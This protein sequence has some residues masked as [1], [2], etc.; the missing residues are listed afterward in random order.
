MDHRDDE[1]RDGETAGDYPRVDAREAR[2]LHRPG[3]VGE[4]CA[5]IDAVDDDVLVEVEGARGVL[6]ARGSPKQ[7][8]CCKVRW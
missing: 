4:R 7:H 1:L 6:H 8:R 2:I 5:A 3:E